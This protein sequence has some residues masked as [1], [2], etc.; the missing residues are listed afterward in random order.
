[1]GS[2]NLND[3]NGINNNDNCDDYS[4]EFTI[5]DCYRMIILRQLYSFSSKQK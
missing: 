2:R 5:L 4:S 1:M 3:N